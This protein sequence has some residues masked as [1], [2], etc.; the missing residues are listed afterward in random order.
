MIYLLKLHPLIQQDFNEAYG[1]YEDKQKGL[2][3]RF[4]KAV[5][6]KMEQIIVRPQVFGSRGNKGF[7]EAKIEFFPYHIVYK[8][9]ERKREIYISS[10]HHNSK[11]PKK[12]YRK[13]GV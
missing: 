10:I 1:W 12:K 5:R 13:G 7:R 2:G 4:L 6:G 11:H 8:I 9:N 3:D